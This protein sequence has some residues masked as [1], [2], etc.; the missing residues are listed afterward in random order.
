MMFGESWRPCKIVQYEVKRKD[1]M[2][3]QVEEIDP[4]AP[5]IVHVLPGRIRLLF[6]GFDR[7]G[8]SVIATVEIPL[9]VKS[10][11]LMDVVVDKPKTFRNAK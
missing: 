3:T 9:E 2:V 11:I 1:D 6:F 5:G 4:R 10:G 7:P 8:G